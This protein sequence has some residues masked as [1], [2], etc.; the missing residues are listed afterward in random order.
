[1]NLTDVLNAV[2]RAVAADWDD[3]QPRIAVI[4]R[5]GLPTVYVSTSRVLEPADRHDVRGTV[6]SALAPYTALAPAADVV[7]LRRA[8]P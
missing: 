4:E 1:M 8:A 6:R 7:F 5:D 3:D 2:Q